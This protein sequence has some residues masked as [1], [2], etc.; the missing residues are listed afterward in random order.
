MTLLINQFALTRQK[1]NLTSANNF[2]ILK[3]R[4]DASETGT[5]TWGDPVEIVPTTS[6]LIS[7]KK[8]TALTSTL[9]GF[10]DN[11]LKQDAFVAGDYLNI[12]FRDCIMFM[13]ASAAI[14]NGVEVQCDPSTSKIATRVDPNT[15][16]GIT[17]E[18][19]SGN[20]ILV[21]VLI[22]TPIAVPDAGEGVTPGIVT[23][24]KTVVVDAN[25]DIA[26]FRNLSAVNLIAG[27]SGTV[28]TASIF[29]ATA[30]KGSLLIQCSDQT[31]DTVVTLDVNAM[32]QATQFNLADPGIATA[33]LLSSTAQIT[34]AEA[35]ILDGA[36]LTTA[37]LNRLDDSAEI[38]TIDS[39]VAVDAAKINTNI[40]NTTSGAG[41]V[42]L[43]APGAAM[44]GKIKNIQMTVDGGDVT[45][46]LT[47]VQGGTA[48]TTATFAAVGEQLVLLGASNSKW[49][50]I[51]E[52]GVTLS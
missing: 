13:E 4:I 30:L 29:P 14:N 36:T 8:A 9:F 25:K 26:I 35:D 11:S 52:F 10:I 23:A 18:K 15:I 24:S 19:A 21:P 43:A 42:T 50:V 47:N 33:Y 48:A 1:G 51:K 46:A 22:T 41:A 20:G 12:A 5:L 16:C 7:V 3:C 49:T 40:D 32:G 31:G 28:G 6:G 17:L 44:V 38:E 39:G 45:L 2:N 37:E 27:A 34:V